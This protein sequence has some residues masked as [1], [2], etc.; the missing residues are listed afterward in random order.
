MKKFLRFA[1]LFVLLAVLGVGIA[2]FFKYKDVSLTSVGFFLAV[3]LIIC[4]GIGS[5]ATLFT[6]NYKN[7]L[8]KASENNEFKN[9]APTLKYK[10]EE[11]QTQDTTNA[12][13]EEVKHKI[14]KCHYCKCK[15]DNSLN[16]CPN[17]G[18]PPE[19]EN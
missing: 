11:L 3:S 8:D 2:L 1:P 19:N 15:F 9:L 10:I 4:G 5:L 17:C 7:K 18:A 16:R 6:I 14:I 12:P 13:T